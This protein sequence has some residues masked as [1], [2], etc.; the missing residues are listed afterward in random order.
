[1]SKSRSKSKEEAAF[2]LYLAGWLKS[3]IADMVNY[4]V[5]TIGRWA[6]DNNWDERKLKRAVFE[7]NN[8]EKLMKIFTFQIEAMEK[9]VNE[10]IENGDYIP[11][12]NGNFDALQ[13]AYSIIK[14][15]FNKFKTYADII[16]EFMEYVQDQDLEVA[17]A[18][19]PIS[20]RFIAHKASLT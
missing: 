5:N 20:K 4:S 9:Q 6:K 7:Q 11:F 8:I 18:L 19:S 15:Q 1:M 2:D 16:N 13:K 14:P 10:R 17:K 3:D 12:E